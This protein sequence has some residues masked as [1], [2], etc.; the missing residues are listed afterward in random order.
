MSKLTKYGKRWKVVYRREARIFNSFLMNLIF[1]GL[2]VFTA[3]TAMANT[4]ICAKV[5]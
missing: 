3:A 2:L 4:V 5:Q 1:S